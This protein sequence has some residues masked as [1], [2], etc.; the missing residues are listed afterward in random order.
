M[1]FSREDFMRSGHVHN[2]QAK[3]NDQ[4]DNNTGEYGVIFYNRAKGTHRRVET[5]DKC[6]MRGRSLW[7]G[8]AGGR[9]GELIVHYISA[10]HIQEAL[11]QIAARPKQSNLF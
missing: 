3:V 4:Q 6:V 10:V 7:G 2:V 9:G 1:S 5:N 11:P 8:C